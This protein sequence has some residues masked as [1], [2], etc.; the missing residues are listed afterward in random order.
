[1]T[2][3]KTPSQIRKD[4]P[5]F[6]GFVA[7]FPDACLAAS[8]LSRIGNEKHNPGQEMHWAFDKSTD[9]GDCIIRHQTD[10]DELD[11]ET[12]LLHATAVFWRAGAQLQTLLESRDPAL[13]ARRSAQRERALKG[14]GKVP[15]AKASAADVKKEP[16]D[17]EVEKEP[18]DAVAVLADLVKKRGTT[19]EDLITAVRRGCY[20]GTSTPALLHQ[21]LFLLGREKELLGANF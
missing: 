7:Y 2:E 4:Q 20:R 14:R 9:H 5:V 13:H 19:E 8:E 15:V 18:F 6:R 3:K 1:V 11:E 16:F 12:A 10:F 21:A 17:A